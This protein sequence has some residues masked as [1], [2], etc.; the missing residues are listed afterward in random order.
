[1]ASREIHVNGRSYSIDADP[2][3]SL[4]S[5]LRDQ[6]EEAQRPA[7]HEP[8]DVPAGVLH[9][10]QQLDMLSGELNQPDLSTL[11]RDRLPAVVCGAA[12]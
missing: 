11:D 7:A 10:G 12:R 9:F 2:Q 5:V 8:L 4:L 1:M 6:L 3:E